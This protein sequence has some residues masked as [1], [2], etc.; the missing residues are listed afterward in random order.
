MFGTNPCSRGISY[1]A[2]YSCAAKKLIASG[3]RHI[4]NVHSPGGLTWSVS[5]MSIF[6]TARLTDLGSNTGYR[7]LTSLKMS[8]D[9]IIHHGGSKHSKQYV[10]LI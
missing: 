6:D 2:K 10:T 9:L 4:V 8:N 7:T 5:M 1:Q 3:W